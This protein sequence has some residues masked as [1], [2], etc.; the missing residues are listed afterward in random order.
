MVTID[1]P[2]WG[3]GLGSLSTIGA[4][5]QVGVWPDQQ[6][7]GQDAHQRLDNVVTTILSALSSVLPLLALPDL[8][9]LSFT[10]TVNHS[11][12]YTAPYTAHYIL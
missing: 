12:L 10:C 4:D 2:G 1:V 9:A 3:L 8:R 11:T 5:V 7:A 6:Q